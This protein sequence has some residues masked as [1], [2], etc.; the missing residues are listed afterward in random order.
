MPGVVRLRS[1]QPVVEAIQIDRDT[2]PGPGEISPNEM[3]VAQAAGWMMGHGYRDFE[4]AKPTAS[5]GACIVLS[6]SD[7]LIV[8]PG[9]WIAFLEGNFERVES[10]RMADIFEVIPAGE[11]VYLCGPMAGKPLLNKAMFDEVAEF[12][13]SKG[14]VPVNPHD[15]PPY[16]HPGKDCEVVYGYKTP[17]GHDGG[18][19]LRADI[20]VM[21]TCDRI[22]R[23][24]GWE[25]SKGAT[26][27]VEVATR[28]G[29]PM[30]DYAETA[31]QQIRGGQS[32]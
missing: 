14:R 21:V 16:E 11:R 2:T 32:V 25:E 9:D 5:R 30:E 6:R 15:I 10:Y 17:E 29:I 20:A 3:S 18:C 12:V 1:K 31:A 4:V 28:L 22:I 7:P 24:P 26:I 27:E 8:Y 13:K 19:Y 23:L